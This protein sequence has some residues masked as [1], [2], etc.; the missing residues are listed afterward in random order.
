MKMARNMRVVRMSRKDIL[1]HNWSIVEL[2]FQRIIL[3]KY[4]KKHEQRNRTKVCHIVFC[5]VHKCEFTFCY[6]IVKTVQDLVAS[7]IDTW[8]KSMN[9]R[10]LFESRVLWESWLPGF[11]LLDPECAI[12]RFFFWNPGSSENPDY[13][14]TLKSLSAHFKSRSKHQTKNRK[15]HPIG[16]SKRT[17]CVQDLISHFFKAAMMKLLLLIEIGHHSKHG[18]ALL[19]SMHKKGK[20]A[21]EMHLRKKSS[22]QKK[23]SWLF[24]YVIHVRR[25]ISEQREKLRSMLILNFLSWGG[26]D[27]F[28]QF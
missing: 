20:V 22:R 26:K 10:F 18:I 8:D 7:S 5:S 24:S 25:E 3:C 27:W 6:P 23:R 14:D 12:S 19:L 9:S 21:K 17:I 15:H 1:R 28:C 11:L 4:E 16:Y 13:L 2:N